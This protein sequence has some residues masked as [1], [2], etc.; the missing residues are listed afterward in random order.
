[1]PRASADFV[2]AG[3]YKIY[4]W[5]KWQKGFDLGTRALGRFGRGSNINSPSGDLMIQG[6]YHLWYQHLID[7]HAVVAYGI[8]NSTF[9]YG[10]GIRLN[11]LELIEDPTSEM[12]I[13]GLQRGVLAPVLKNFMVY[14][15]AEFLHFSFSRPPNADEQALT[16]ETS[17]WK[18][19]PGVGAQ[20]YFYFSNS[21]AGRFYLETTISYMKIDQSHYFS[22]YLGFG[23][24]LI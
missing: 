23:A 12:F 21:F 20:W 1:M 9:A 16:Y 22:P 18:A 3:D 19:L 7:V 6:S 14:L 24:E 13:R 11:M 4:L 8:S 5:P 2:D 15:N 10:G 17:T